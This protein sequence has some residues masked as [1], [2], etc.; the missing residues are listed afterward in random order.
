MRACITGVGHFVPEKRLTN[1][2][3]EKMVETND[4]WIVSRTGIKERRILDPGLGT[5]HMAEQASRQALENAG[6]FPEE[7]DVILL[8]TVTPDY[9][10]PSA[11][12]L[13]E[14]ALGAVNSWGIDMNG[15][16]TGFLCAMATG[17]QFIESG[18]HRKI[19]VIGADTMS[20]I[21]DY[22]DR[23]TCILFGDGAGAVLLE[24]AEEGDPNGVVD[25]ILK[26]DGTGAPF[27]ALP[28]GGSRKPASPETVAAREHFVYQD[29][30]T[31]FK[32]AVNGMS[33][34]SGKLL[35]RNGLSASD[36][37]LL[38]PHQANIRIIESVARKLGLSESQVFVNIQNYGNTTAGTIPIALSEAY[39]EHRRISRGDWTLLTAFGAGFTWGSLLMR[40]SLP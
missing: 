24:P 3:L 17:V 36:V 9:P 12:A 6:V 26:L 18:R 2:E 8:A 4:E 31:V 11:V 29:G 21:L 7:L 37:G 14:S 15:G 23:N 40:W 5:S 33:D 25:F 10:V 32:N 28:A 35:K 38:V 39:N 30:R 34:V 27:L 16:C 1:Q 19:L 22:T 20:S 13:V